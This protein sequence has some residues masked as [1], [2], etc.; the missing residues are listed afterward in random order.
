MDT[1]RWQEQRRPEKLFSKNDLLAG[2]YNEEK[3]L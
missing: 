2:A 3:S 1:A